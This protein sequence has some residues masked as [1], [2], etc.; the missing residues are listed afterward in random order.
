MNFEIGHSVWEHDE[1]V[2]TIRPVGEKPWRSAPIGGTVEKLQAQAIEKWLQSAI[3][4]L[5][6]IFSNV[7]AQHTVL[8]DFATCAPDL[9]AKYDDEGDLY[10]RHCGQP[11]SR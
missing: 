4:E 3:N 2:I 10:C 8:V 11:L 9:H 6:T 7:S 1:F 5:W